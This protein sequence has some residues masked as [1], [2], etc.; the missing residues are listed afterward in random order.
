MWQGL[1]TAAHWKVIL[2]K[3]AVWKKALGLNKKDKDASIKKAIELFPEMESKLARKK[4]HDRA[5]AL[6]LAY[7]GKKLIEES[8]GR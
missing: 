3:P 6:L 7:Y 4:D 1:A 8:H 5:E 2:V